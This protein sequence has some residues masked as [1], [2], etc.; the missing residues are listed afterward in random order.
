MGNARKLSFAVDVSF[1]WINITNSNFIVN[2][3]SNINY[4]KLYIALVCKVIYFSQTKKNPPER[5]G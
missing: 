4:R 2:T 3:N 1:R 5:V